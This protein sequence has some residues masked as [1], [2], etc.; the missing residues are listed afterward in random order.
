MPESSTQEPK[1]VLIIANLLKSS[2]RI[3]RLI[4]HLPSFGWLPT[5]VTPR[6][7][8]NTERIFNAPP[9]NIR[10]L[11]I[12]IIETGEVRHY[13][14]F[15]EETPALQTITPIKS[16]L[17]SLD[18]TDGRKIAEIIRKYYWRLYL[19]ANFP[20]VDK[21][22]K[23]NALRTAR[24]LLKK[25]KFD[26]MISSSSPV[27]S[28]IIA[29]ELKKEFGI[30]WIADYR[31]LWTLNHNYPFGPIMRLFDVRLEKKTMRPCDA[32]V[33]VSE[34]LTR[35]LSAMFREKEVLTI[36]NGFDPDERIAI[37]PLTKEF[38]MTYTGQIYHGKQ[39]FTLLIDSLSELLMEGRMDRNRVRLRFYGPIDEQLKRYAEE[40]KLADVLEQPGAISREE[41]LI[42]QSESQMLIFFNWDDPS[43]PGI[44]SGSLKLLEYLQAKRPILVTG[45]NKNNV[46]SKI[47]KETAAGKIGTSIQETKD[48]LLSAYDRY[49]ESGAVPFEGKSNEIDKY[50]F[51]HSVR[52]YASLMNRIAGQM[53]EKAS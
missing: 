50:D 25:R 4:R 43:Q 34:S 3:P 44:G 42:R 41:S 35:D 46:S 30:P 23:E 17:A 39:D 13:E 33:T 1:R 45:R 32:M 38:T 31:D 26:I 2:P 37:V 5:I 22:W 14:Q 48:I 51:R 18:S 10:H 11:G 6:I 52:G 20:D 21:N 29:S 16:L 28:H 36:P 7:P 9:K 53:V 47:V 19:T 49:L 40:K 27:I 12:E 15:K 8:T 24:E